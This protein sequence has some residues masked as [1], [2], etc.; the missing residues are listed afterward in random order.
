MTK[1]E[2]SFLSPFFRKFPI[3]FLCTALLL[4]LTLSIPNHTPNHEYDLHLP[5]QDNSTE[6]QGAN[7]ADQVQAIRR[8][9]IIQTCMQ[10]SGQAVMKPMNP[11]FATAFW[12]AS[13]VLDE[14]EGIGWCQINKVATTSLAAVILLHES[15][16]LEDVR[17]AMTPHNDVPLNAMVK[18][19]KTKPNE[20]GHM[21]RGEHRKEYFT[22][23]VVMHPFVRLVSAF[24]DKVKNR[25]DTDRRKSI[26]RVFNSTEKITFPEF[27]EYLIRTPPNLMDR[28]WAPYTKMCSPC[29]HAYSAVLKMETLEKD[30]D[31]LFEKVML[32]KVG[33][34]WINVAKERI[35]TVSGDEVVE[36]YFKQLR[37]EDIVRLYNKYEVDFIMFD[38]D[39]E[40]ELFVQMGR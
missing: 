40:V 37:K 21:I 32:E 5:F 31:W 20:R 6:Y 7:D 27:V 14:N 19:R 15:G 4:F 29:T 30:T 17:V 38:Y 11:Y 16:S 36:E 12:P 23:L 34:D 13:L 3:V 22:F 33:E 1:N 8:S 10:Y 2:G 25:T 28:S 35:S 9:K 26:Q 39:K 24:K 18:R